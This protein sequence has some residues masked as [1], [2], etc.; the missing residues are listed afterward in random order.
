[1]KAK[2][3]LESIKQGIEVYGDSFLEWWVYTEDIVSLSGESAL[4]EF[5]TED[6][7]GRTKS[8]EVECLDEKGNIIDRTKERKLK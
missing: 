1:M 7:K 4:I 8:W 5:W 6:I 3:V 2:D